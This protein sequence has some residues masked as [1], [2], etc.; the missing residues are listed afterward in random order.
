MLKLLDVFADRATYRPAQPAV[1]QSVLAN[2]TQAK[3]RGRVRA[4]LVTL[5][6]EV[7]RAETE[8]ELAPGARL[9][10]P[11]TLGLPA[12]DLRGY[13]VEAELLDGRGRLIAQAG[14]ALDV[15]TD[16]TRAPRY[17]FL[18]DFAPGESEAESQR[19]LRALARFHV[20]AVQIYDWMYRH[21]SFLPPSP[22]FIDPLGRNLS[23]DVVR[24]KVRLAQQLGMRAQAYVAIYAAAPDYFKAHPE[25]GLYRLDG[26]PYTLSEP[27]LGDWL[28]ITNIADRAWLGQ[29]SA[30]CRRAIEAVGF[31][32]LHL[33][34]YG[35]V[36]TGYT[37]AGSRVDVEQA[38]PEFLNALRSAV[39]GAAT[40]FN[41]VNVWPLAA[42]AASSVEPLY[43]EVW[44]PHDTLRDLREIILRARELRGGRAPVL[45]AYL[46]GLLPAEAATRQGALHALRRLTAAIYLNGGSHIALGEG[47][48]VLRH[49]YFP[50]Y[51]PLRPAEARAV[52]ADYDFIARYS[53]YFFDPA[54]RDISTTATGGLNDDLRLEAPRSGPMA[55]PDSIWTIAR[56]R[57]NVVTLGLV[58]LRGMAST[59]WNAAQPAPRRL[60]RLRLRVQLERPVAQ[61]F[62]ASP[63]R[64]SGRAVPLLVEREGRL[65]FVTVPELGYWGLVILR[66]ADEWRA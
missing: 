30:E 9:T 24:R 12:D 1:I 19:R 29:L 32:G 61:A 23:L 3:F 50:N 42:V 7:T 34:Q 27:A 56:A 39:G 60:R 65:A 13:G 35:F 51:Y 49:P 18:A 28:F 66:L 46:S 59:A 11:L 41:A 4:R 38:L 6:G 62:F 36:R 44:P 45:A 22:E 26:T 53:E 2:A 52:R 31:D 25:Q 40:V 58:N 10:V 57:G 8:V 43:I 64:G 47:G 54:W 63:D 15:A 37:L 16:W 21:H 33:D 17:G 5:D 48:G 55:E 20:N 14:T